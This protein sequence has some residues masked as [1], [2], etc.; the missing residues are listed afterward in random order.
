V[1]SV[2]NSLCNRPV[3]HSTANGAGVLHES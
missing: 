2:L 1:T 3:T